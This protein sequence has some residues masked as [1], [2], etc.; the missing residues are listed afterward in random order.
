MSRFL[1]CILVEP[2][3]QHHLASPN[4]PSIGF[5]SRCQRDQQ[6]QFCQFCLIPFDPLL[7]HTF[8]LRETAGTFRRIGTWADARHQ[9]RIGARHAIWIH[10]RIPTWAEA[11]HQE[12]IEARFVIGILGR[13][14][15]WA[16]ARLQGCIWI[17]RHIETW[18]KS[19]SWAPAWC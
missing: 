6:S 16:E 7:S 11:R 10:Q 17:I 13:T 9:G 19:L 5:C 8:I 14:G 4:F 12:M 18:A 1:H 15:T 3:L 2:A